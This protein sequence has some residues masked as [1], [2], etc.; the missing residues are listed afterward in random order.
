[1]V[2]VSHKVSK[3]ASNSFWKL[4]L[5]QLQSVLKLKEE[6]KIARKIPKFTQIRRRLYKKNV[7]RIS[8]EIAYME[9]ATN[10]VILVEDTT[11]TPTSKFPPNLYTKLYE[12]ASVKVIK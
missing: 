1:M 7:P 11:T 9:K 12:Q 2:E 4:V 6:H 3:V 5:E 8:L 10:K